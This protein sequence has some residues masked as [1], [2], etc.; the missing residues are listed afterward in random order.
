MRFFN[1]T[2]KLKIQSRC[3]YIHEG[4]HYVQCYVASSNYDLSKHAQK[5][6]LKKDIEEW[7]FHNSY[8]YIAKQIFEGIN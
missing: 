6:L 1:H 3:G 8:M 5:N 4:I 2:N 7:F